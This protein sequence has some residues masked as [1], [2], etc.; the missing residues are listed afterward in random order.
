MNK[1]YRS[2]FV[3][4]VA[5]L[6]VVAA[7]S[8]LLVQQSWHKF[9]SL[10]GRLTSSLLESFRLAEDFQARLQRLNNTLLRFTARREPAT[11]AEFQQVSHALNQ[12]I[13]QH[14]PQMNEASNLTTEQERQLFRQINAA[15]DDY[16]QAAN[17]VLSNR[18]PAVVTTPVFSQLDQFEQ[19]SQRLLTLGSQLADA[20]RQA[21]ESFLGEAN[22]ALGVLRSLMIAAIV[23]MVGLVGAL[24]M[25]IYRDLIAPLRVRLVQSEALLERQEK[26]ATLGTLAAGIAHEIRNPLTSIKARLYT[27]G[28]HIQGNPAGLTDTAVINDEIARLERIVQDVLS[29]ARPSEPTRRVVRADAPLVEVHSLMAGTLEKIDVRLVF[30]PGEKLFVSMDVAL[31][32]Q[33][34]INLVRNAAEAIEGGGTVTLRVRAGRAV[35]QGTEREVAILEVAD[36]GKGIPPEIEKRLFD[37]F[38]TTK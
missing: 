26:L 22:R 34:L 8:L 38:F 11:L 4:L 29:F 7:L 35:L 12:W 20:H 30:E 28:K 1:T 19:Q 32:K 24:G 10:E 18:Q 31:I 23:V 13:D 21:Q 6:A 2:R 33:V 5:A 16:L 15:Y 37:P 14:D 3:L 27:L 9:T 36:T 25:V 17:S